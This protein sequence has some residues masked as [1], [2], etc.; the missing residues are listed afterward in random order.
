[1]A[2]IAFDKPDE[3]LALSLPQEDRHGWGF[4]LLLGTVATLFLRPAD[5][6]PALEAWPVYQFLIFCCLLVAARATLRQ[7]KHRSILEQPV[8]ACLLLLLVAVGLS[9]LSHG[10]V[11]G[12]RTS[13][14]EVCKLVALYLLIVALANT[15]YRL[16]K[17]IQWLA[18]SITVVAALALLDRYELLSVAAL[19]SI[20]D[21]GAVSN[22][23]TEI[24]ERIRGTGIF[25]DP[26]DFGLI[27]VMGLVLSVSFL[28][29]PHAGW[30]RHLWLAPCCILVGTIAL[31]H[32][33]GAMLSLLCAVPAV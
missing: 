16:I 11:W 32:S 28:L 26:N 30:L 23:P 22:H 20:Q 14:V 13:V 29:R 19:E 33:R 10:F 17:L 24:V 8:L 9:H 12:A 15:P 18:I 21:R 5:L 2:S 3:S 6:V 27:L 25:Q 1:M 4:L 31:T 7:L